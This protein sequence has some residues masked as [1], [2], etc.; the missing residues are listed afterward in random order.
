MENANPITSIFGGAE[1]YMS[2]LST[3]NF[4]QTLIPNKHFSSSLNASFLVLSH[5]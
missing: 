3:V 4:V 1:N 2:Q 5:S